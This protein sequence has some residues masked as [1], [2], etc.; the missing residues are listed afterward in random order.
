MKKL[1]DFEE[2]IDVATPIIN[3]FVS[4]AIGKKIFPETDEGDL[5]IE[6]Q[7]E[8]FKKKKELEKFTEATSLLRKQIW[9]LMRHKMNNMIVK[10]MAAKRDYRLL[11]LTLDDENEFFD[12]PQHTPQNNWDLKLDLEKIL[13]KLNPEHVEI[14][15]KLK[16][17]TI[18]DVARE[19]QITR[20]RVKTIVHKIRAIFKKEN[21]F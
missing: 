16:D 6:L 4:K 19:Q 14:C 8:L 17:G 12:E 7:F 9:Y 2:L 3:S 11:D 1:N 21:F 13:R 20:E 18:A 10:R 15:I 5:I